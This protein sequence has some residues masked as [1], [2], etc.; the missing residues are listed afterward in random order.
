MSEKVYRRC[1]GMDVRKNTIVVCV[2]PL[3]GQGSAAVR[4]TYRTFR[5]ELTR[6]QR[7]AEYLQD[8]RLDPSFVPPEIRELRQILRHRLS[9]LQ[10]RGEVHNQSGTCSRRPM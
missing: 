7:I 8:G 5:N 3:D 10:E 9:L 6:M 2:L 4:K 1:C